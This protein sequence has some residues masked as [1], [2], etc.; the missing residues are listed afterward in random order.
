MY[1]RGS[2]APSR[3]VEAAKETRKIVE[4]DEKATS[5]EFGVPFKKEATSYKKK[6]SRKKKK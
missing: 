2:K 1:D 4:E 5:E 6:S 3:I